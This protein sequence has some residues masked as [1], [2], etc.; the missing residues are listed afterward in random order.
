MS[1]YK[2][3]YFIAIF[4]F[5]IYHAVILLAHKN[6]LPL[7]G[8]LITQIHI[9]VIQSFSI[10]LI[11]V[12]VFVSVSLLIRKPPQLLKLLAIAGL[13]FL[14][15]LF[16]YRVTALI[17]DYRVKPLGDYVYYPELAQAFLNKELF[18]EN[19]STLMDLTLFNGKWYLSF[20]PLG[21]ILLLP[22][23]AKNGVESINPVSFSTFWGALA[24][25]WFWL[26]MNGLRR[27]GIILISFTSTFWLAALLGFGSSF[28]YISIAGQIWFIS[29]V[30]AVAFC[31]LAFWL[32][33]DTDSFLFTSSALAIGM[34]ARPTIGFAFFFLLGIVI[35]KNPGFKQN[36]KKF[37]YIL[38]KM[39]IPICVVIVA[40]LSYNHLRFNNWLDFGYSTMNVADALKK[41][42]NNYGQFNFHYF[43]NNFFYTF[44]ALPSYVKN[45]LF[46]VPSFT[47]MSLFLTMPV[48]FL[49]FF[50]FSKK[51][52]VKGAYLSILL[53]LF[54]LLLYFNTGAPQFG[55]RFSLDYIVPVVAVLAIV[56]EDN[57]KEWLFKVLIICGICVNILG[58]IWYFGKLC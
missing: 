17:L 50:T 1:R 11:I 12:L 46:F 30:L 54:T 58:V 41:N 27:K 6:Y 35:S 56:V 32:A 34:L 24:I 16:I 47:G 26:G 49:L 36:P 4:L 31:C 3:I 9:Q 37:S 23:V 5:L 52:W 22:L 29:H 55:N 7:F 51:D 33:A 45:C 14:I 40:L 10:E 15:L 53:S 13:I 20:P 48:L 19:P 44:L 21:A 39:M 2:K 42:L 38:F 25:A 18:L 8:S 57:R 28:F 43:G